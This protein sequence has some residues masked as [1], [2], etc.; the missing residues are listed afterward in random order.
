MPRKKGIP[1]KITSKVKDK[2]SDIV[3]DALD[4]LDLETFSKAEK[5]KLIQIGVQYIVP[6]LKQVEEV[7]EEP[8]RQFQIEVIESRSQLSEKELDEAIKI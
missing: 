3:N 7:T 2:L 1:N 8:P 6:R 5:L 4:S